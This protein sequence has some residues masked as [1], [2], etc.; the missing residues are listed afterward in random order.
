[1][2]INEV[3]FNLLHSFVNERCPKQ[4]DSIKLCKD[5]HLRRGKCIHPLRPKV[6]LVGERV[7]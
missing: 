1:M 7:V 2:T 4:G 3:H 5:C 6:R